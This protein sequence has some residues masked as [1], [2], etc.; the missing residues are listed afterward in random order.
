[1][2]VRVIYMVKK[3]LIGIFVLA[4]L[5]FFAWSGIAPLFAKLDTAPLSD[6]FSGNVKKGD[7]VSG[8][9]FNAT[10]EVVEVTHTMGIPYAWEHYY[11]IYD[12]E[13]QT[14][15]TLKASGNWYTDVYMASATDRIEISG[16]VKQLDFDTRKEIESSFAQ[17]HGSDRPQFTNLY[18]DIQSDLYGILT[19]VAVAVMIVIIAGFVLFSSADT[20]SPIAKLLVFLVMADLA[21]MLHILAMV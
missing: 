12:D 2:F 1:M 8:D 6:A 13:M 5:V 17:I 3:I 4:M 15:I 7:Y 11:F 9:I 18:I 14:C 10:P 21:F 20:K 16:V 19:I